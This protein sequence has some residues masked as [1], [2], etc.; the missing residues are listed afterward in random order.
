VNKLWLVFR[1]EYIRRIKTKGFVF[2]VIS[3]PLMIIMAIGLGF[4]SARMQLNRKP[5][6][7][8]NQSK[9]ITDAVFSKPSS[10]ILSDAVEIIEYAQL[11]TGKSDV[12]LG[13]TQVFFVIPEDFM[14]HGNIQGYAVEKPGENAFT[15]LERGL[16]TALI[17]D[18]NE[19]IIHRIESGSDF[20][21]HSLDGSKQ[22]NM[23]DWFIIFFPFAS[24]LIFMIVINISGGYL[25]QSVVDEK[26]NRTME[27]IVT[28]TSPWELMIGKIIGNLSVGFTQALIWFSSAIVGLTI[29]K[30]IFGIGQLENVQMVHLILFLGII[31][32]G[33]VLFA[34]LMTIVGVTA[35]EMRE[36][37]QVSLL[38]TLPL[39]S[40]FWLAAA[41]LQH[42]DNPLTI[43][44]SIFPLTSIV[45]MPLRASIS[46]V[47]PLQILF[48]VLVIWVS[49]ITALMLASKAFRMGMLQ[50]GKRIRLGTLIRNLAEK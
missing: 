17:K 9:L 41:I 8:L 42:P 12:I 20:T 15:A 18:Y 30:L 10:G 13:N 16:K 50:Y 39:A 31:L 48:A 33:F 14:D 22:V 11:E 49:A 26:E 37:Q 35:S 28:S 46:I 5:I 2:A 44:L 38:F 40:P 45:T 47:P 29:V 24:G 43:F 19:E 34:A 27:L 36:A 4:L 25:L 7:I 23:R 32:P 3:M 21:I 6:G 1:F